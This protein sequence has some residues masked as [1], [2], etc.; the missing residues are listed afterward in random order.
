MADELQSV[1]LE[2]LRISWPDFA[3]RR[4]ALN[5]HMPRVERLSEHVHDFS[6]VLI[7]LRGH[8]VQH[9]AGEAVPVS[10]GTVLFVPANLSHRFEKA[11]TRRPVC[12]AL[13]FEGGNS[14]QWNQ[15]GALTGEELVKAERWLLEL[16]ELERRREAVLFSIA[17]V[18]LRII[19]LV[20]QVLTRSVDETTR[21]PLYRSAVRVIQRHGLQGIT[22]G[23][24]AEEMGKSLD[25][26]NR[27]LREETGMTVGQLISQE[28]LDVAKRGLSNADILIGSVASDAGFDD[29][30]YFSRWF[31]RET[32]QTPSRWRETMC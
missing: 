17:A 11:D 31:R 1:L 27:M 21:G 6:Q 25:H 18:V 16:H 24:V 4:V 15:V 9:L 2:D 10:R 29:Q 19:E 5:Q 28:R 23:M 8:G 26:V 30:N 22:A 3:L 7:Y 14:E 32:G 12:L 20:E 13:D